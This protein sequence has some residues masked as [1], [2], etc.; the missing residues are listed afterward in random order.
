MLH[1][2]QIAVD[3]YFFGDAAVTAETAVVVAD[4]AVVVGAAATAADCVRLNY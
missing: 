4:G 3:D 2:W 1:P